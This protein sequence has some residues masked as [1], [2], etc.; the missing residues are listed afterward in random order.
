MRDL[1]NVHELITDLFKW[2]TKPAEWEQYRL[3][4]EQVAFFREYGYLADVKLSLP[5]RT[6]SCF[7]P[8]APGALRKDFMMCCGI[9]LL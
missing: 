5:I 2:A 9:R 3:S 6:G 1:S 4:N 8:W 7:M